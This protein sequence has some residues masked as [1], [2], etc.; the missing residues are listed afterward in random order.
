MLSAALKLFVSEGYENAS[1]DEIAAQ[2]GLTKGAVYFYFKGKL[3]LLH[4][5]LD[6]ALDLYRGIFRQMGQ[7]DLSPTD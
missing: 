5:L 6:E 2:A 7:S 1:I 3:A 4:A